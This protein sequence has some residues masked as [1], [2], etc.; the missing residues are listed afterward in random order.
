MRHD[1]RILGKS[2]VNRQIDVS[3]R[4]HLGEFEIFVAVDCKDWQKPVDIGD[5]GAFADLVEDVRANKG[6]MVCNA[7]FTSGAKLRA[8]EKGIDLFKAVDAETRDQDTLGKTKR[9]R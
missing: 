7:G 5:V 3:V 6:A 1:E 9:K 8:V 2:G 4:Y